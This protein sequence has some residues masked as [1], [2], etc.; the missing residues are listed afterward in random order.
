LFYFFL[1]RRKERNKLPK[2]H[3]PSL[4]FKEAE[5]KIKSPQI[6]HFSNEMERGESS[7]ILFLMLGRYMFYPT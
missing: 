3:F 5:K 4:I 7:V 1:K 6:K 2:Y